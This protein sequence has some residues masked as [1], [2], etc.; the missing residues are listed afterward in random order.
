[1]GTQNI[2]DWDTVQFCYQC[3]TYTQAD[4]QTNG[5]T[6]YAQSFDNVPISLSQLK[7]TECIVTLMVNGMSVK[8]YELLCSHLGLA[9]HLDP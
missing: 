1:M 9:L 3:P 2:F 5:H 4:I 7:Y 8:I 6:T